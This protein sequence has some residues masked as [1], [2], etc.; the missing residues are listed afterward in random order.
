MDLPTM[1][2]TLKYP[3]GSVDPLTISLASIEDWVLLKDELDDVCFHWLPTYL[4]NF[5]SLSSRM[6]WTNGRPLA[7]ILYWSVLRNNEAGTWVRYMY[8]EKRPHWG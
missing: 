2:L 6:S 8:L 3:E 4:R 7:D 1:E 5:F